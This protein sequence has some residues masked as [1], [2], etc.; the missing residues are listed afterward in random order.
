MD[1]HVWRH[2]GVDIRL[3]KWHAHT[4]AKRVLRLSRLLLENRRRRRRERAAEALR[5]KSD[6]YYFHTA[7]WVGGCKEEK[8]EAASEAKWGVLL[9]GACGF[10]SDPPSPI[11][12]LPYTSRAIEWEGEWKQRK[13]K[14]NSPSDQTM[15]KWKWKEQDRHRNREENHETLDQNMT[16]LWWTSNTGRG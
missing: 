8:E 14:E 11:L 16:K 9:Q 10:L 13:G 5:V 6:C 3:R 15:S 2:A 1:S 7:W 4:S 12:S